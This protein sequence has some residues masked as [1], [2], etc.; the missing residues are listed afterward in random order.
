MPPTAQCCLSEDL[1]P[2]VSGLYSYQPPLKERKGNT[3]T[4]ACV[5]TVL[6]ILCCVVKCGKSFPTRF[7][8]QIYLPVRSLPHSIPPF[9]QTPSAQNA[10]RWEVKKGSINFD[11]PGSSVVR[12]RLYPRRAFTANTSPSAGTVVG[13]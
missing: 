7:V 5:R 8:T 9:C 13:P 4:G 2:I 3:P 12:T 10:L 1:G 11:P 6:F